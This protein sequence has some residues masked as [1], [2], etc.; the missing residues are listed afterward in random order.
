MPHQ[1]LESFFIIFCDS[2]DIKNVFPIPLNSAGE[3][4]AESSEVCAWHENQ[5]KLVGR[6]SPLPVSNSVLPG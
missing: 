3:K 4:E 5:C 6:L 1:S 2:A